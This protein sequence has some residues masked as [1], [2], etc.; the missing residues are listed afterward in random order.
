MLGKG[1]T[2]TFSPGKSNKG[3]LLLH[4]YWCYIRSIRVWPF[5]YIY[6]AEVKAK[7]FKVFRK[8]IRLLQANFTNFYITQKEYYMSRGFFFPSYGRK[9][10]SNRNLIP[11]WC[12]KNGNSHGRSASSL[13]QDLHNWQHTGDVLKESLWCLQ[14]I[15]AFWLHQPG[16]AKITT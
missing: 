12:S 3:Y 7:L 9:P 16:S 6:N 5:M 1:E 2:I 4:L 14:N 13:L 8:R 10:F 15:P 11:G